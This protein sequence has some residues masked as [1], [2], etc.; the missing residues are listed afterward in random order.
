MKVGIFFLHHE[1]VL[2]APTHPPLPLTEQNG[3]DSASRISN[4]KPSALSPRAS[5]PPTL[6]TGDMAAL[7]KLGAVSKHDDGSME[8]EIA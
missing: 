6:A 5:S 8:V 3:G 7:E 1:F 2:L 4:A